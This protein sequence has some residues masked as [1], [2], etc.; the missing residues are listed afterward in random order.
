MTSKPDTLREQAAHNRDRASRLSEHDAAQRLV[1]AGEL[2]AATKEMG[3]DVH[4]SLAAHDESGELS[5]LFLRSMQKARARGATGQAALGRALHVILREHTARISKFM[6][7]RALALRT[8]AI[9]LDANA[10]ALL[11]EASELEAGRPSVPI[12]DRE[13]SFDRPTPTDL[14]AFAPIK[15]DRKEAP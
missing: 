5:A 1:A 10:D 11:A 12:D 3:S 15:S 9:R 8:E 13:A 14:L 7:E 6:F 4:A 2:E